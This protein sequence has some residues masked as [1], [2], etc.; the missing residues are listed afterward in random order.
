LVEVLCATPNP[1]LLHQNMNIINCHT[2]N[3]K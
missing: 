2:Q 3:N 1:E